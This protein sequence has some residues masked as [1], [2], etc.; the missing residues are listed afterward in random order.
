M[1]K[2]RL[3]P[4]VK[5]FL[6]ALAIASVF[7]LFIGINNYFESE[8]EKHIEKVS[9]ECAKKGYGIKSYYT[10]SGDKFYKCNIGG[11]E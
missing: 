11:N 10:N 5:Q 2:R 3:K 7:F 8:M 4:W 6:V 9:S 1:T